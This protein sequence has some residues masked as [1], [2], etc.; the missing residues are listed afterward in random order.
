MGDGGAGEIP[1]LNGVGLVSAQVKAESGA[2][3]TLQLLRGTISRVDIVCS[4]QL[5][6]IADPKRHLTRSLRS[7]L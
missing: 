1:V 7:T 5:K 4:G 6:I 3:V 2:A